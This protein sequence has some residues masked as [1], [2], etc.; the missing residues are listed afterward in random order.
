VL[1][2]KTLRSSTLRLALIYVSLFC[3]AIVALLG[4]VYWSTVFY[5]REKSDHA[6]AAERVL[7][8]TAYDHAGPTALVTLIDRRIDDSHF[9]DWIYLLVDP[10]LVCKRSVKGACH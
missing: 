8:R 10:S 5:L 1:L 9:N 7:L 4:S 3:T 6:I 2:A